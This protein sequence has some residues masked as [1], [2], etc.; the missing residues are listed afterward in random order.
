AGSGFESLAV[1]QTA[2]A[3]PSPAGAFSSMTAEPRPPSEPRA[4]ATRPPRHAPSPLPLDAVARPQGDVGHRRVYPFWPAR[5]TVVSRERRCVGTVRVVRARPGDGPP[6]LE[7]SVD[8]VH[9]EHEHRGHRH[10][11]HN[12]DEE[13]RR[14]DHAPG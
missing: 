4:G 13:P 7:G 1:Y 2:P 10:H 5:R 9:D 14:A 11:E 8:M 6:L 3:G 12:H